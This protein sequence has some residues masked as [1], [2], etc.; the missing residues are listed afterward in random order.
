MDLG[1][2]NNTF[3]FV[4]KTDKQIREAEIGP[5]FSPTYAILFIVDL[6]EKN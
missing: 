5:K 4:F 3:E 6:E 1:S 2:K